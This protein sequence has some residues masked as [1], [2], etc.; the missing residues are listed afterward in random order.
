MLVGPRAAQSTEQELVRRKCTQTGL[1]VARIHAGNDN[2]SW[3]ALAWMSAAA[4]LTRSSG[5][6]EVIKRCANERGI[7]SPSPWRSTSEYCAFSFALP[8]HAAPNSPTGRSESHR[9]RQ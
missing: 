5:D 2:P 6:E 9:L 3:P 8:R 4:A 7:A 1:F